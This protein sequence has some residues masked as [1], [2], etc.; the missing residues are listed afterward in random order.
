MTAE[1][2]WRLFQETGL[3]EAYSLYRALKREEERRAEAA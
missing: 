2:A 3:P 1:A